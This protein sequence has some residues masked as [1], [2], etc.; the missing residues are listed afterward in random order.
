VHYIARVGLDHVK[1]AV[2][3]DADGRRALYAA[4]LAALD[5]EP[6]PWH[7]PEQAM[8]DMRQ[9]SALTVPN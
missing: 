3:D 9:F 5:G 2:L 7:Q 6:D 4:L 1:Q 8:V